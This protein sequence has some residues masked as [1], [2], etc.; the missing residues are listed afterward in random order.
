MSGINNS[1]YNSYYHIVCL[2]A[3]QE[4]FHYLLTPLHLYETLTVSGRHETST[5]DVHKRSFGC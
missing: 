3:A 4:L 1:Y 2:G 5:E